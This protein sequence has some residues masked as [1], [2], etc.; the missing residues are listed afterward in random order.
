MITVLLGI[1]GLS[2]L[3]V[4]HELGHLFGARLAG[5]KVEVFSLGWGPKLITK[6]IKD[7]EW[8]LS[9]FP[10]GGYCKMAGENRQGDETVPG[11]MHYGKAWRR[12]LAVAGGPLF[13]LLF[14]FI[15]AFLLGLTVTTTS[16]LDNRIVALTA[17]TNFVSGDYITSINGRTITTASEWAEIMSLSARRTLQVTVL[18]DGQPV[19]FSETIAMAS[20]SS[21][22]IPITVWAPARIAAFTVSSPAHEAGLEIGDLVTSINNVPIVNSAALSEVVAASAGLPLEVSYERGGQSYV[23]TITPI[24]NEQSSRYLLGVELAGSSRPLAFN[25]RLTYGIASFIY[26][27]RLYVTSLRNLFFGVDLTETISGPLQTTYIIGQIA[28]QSLSGDIRGILMVLSLISLALGVM[29]LLP[30]PILDGGLI[31]LYGFEWLAGKSAPPVVMRVYHT[32]G[33]MALG[34]I[35]FLALSSDVLNLFIRR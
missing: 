29:N 15:L 26:T 8:A 12:L 13:S 1:A 14:A 9:A 20:N 34:F 19:S 25:E 2:I 3:V 4:V 28:Q 31:I 10:L 5:I 23:T 22:I 27:F 33:V 17:N 11:D 32:V 24:F 6:K 18:R 30:I 7:T 35:I 21:A 16:N